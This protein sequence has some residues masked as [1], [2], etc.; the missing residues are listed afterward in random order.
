MSN[1]ERF[2]KLMAGISDAPSN[3]EEFTALH[4]VIEALWQ[5]LSPEQEIRALDSLK[6]TEATAEVWSAAA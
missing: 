2:D 3:D 4:A 6:D 1:A 5:E